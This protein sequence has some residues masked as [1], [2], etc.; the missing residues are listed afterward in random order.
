M[1]VLISKHILGITKFDNPYQMIAADV[2]ESGTITAFD[3][4]QLR[5]L[6][7]NIRTDF[8]NSDSWKFVAV[9]YEFT[10]ANPTAENYPQEVQ[11]A[12]LDRDMNADFVAVKMGDVNGNA[13]PNSFTIAEDRRTTKTFEIDIEDI[14]IKAGERYQVAFT[15]KQLAAIQGYQFTLTY[16]D[17]KLEK[18]HSGLVGVENFG[19]QKMDKGSITTSW[20]QSAANSQ[21]SVEN[22]SQEVTDLFNI[23]FTAL[24]NGK[25]S[26]QLSLISRPT[27]IE[28]YGQDGELMDVQFSFTNSSYEEQFDLFQNQPNPF[29]EQTMI[30]FYLPDDSEVRLILRDEAG[31]LLRVIDADKKAGYNTIQ[32]ESA[33]LTNG[34]IYYQ[35]STKFGSKAKKML[36]LK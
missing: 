36:H 14:M 35:L 28:A 21:Q 34:F 23:E 18:L 1:I 15:T 13:R 9:N 6:I 26:E 4:V 30:G 5:Q 7:L 19:L 27:P 24:K 3:M 17:L 2:N 16:N 31:R 12:D 20:N 10:T 22:D 33:D 25:L 32:L 29:R 11:I 8:T